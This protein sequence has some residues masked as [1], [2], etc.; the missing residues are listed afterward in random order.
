MSFSRDLKTQLCENKSSECC[1]KAECYGFMLF[2]QSFS[3][4][5]ISL[6]TDNEAVAKR[7]AYLISHCFDITAKTEVNKAK[8]TNYKVY[9]EKEAERKR[10]LNLLGLTPDNANT[11]IN[12]DI[13]KKDCCKNA[14]IRGM[15][16]GCGQAADPERE[17]RVD[18]RIKNAE[19]SYAAFDLLYKRGLEPRITLKN[20]TNVVYLKRSECV[21]DFLTLIGAAAL[22]LQVMDARVIKDFRSKLNRKGNFED[23]NTSKVINASIEQ[24]SA[25]EFLIETDKFS[26]LTEELQYAAK[27]RLDNPYAPLSELCKI[28]SI[29][30]TRSGLN[31]RLKKIMEIAQEQRKKE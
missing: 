25:I 29:P 17:Y 15:F 13:I 20:L 11:Y 2:G 22:S 4:Q 3:V 21:E 8:K 10:I 30:I 19:L 5:K 28:S 9:I 18:L 23:A 1:R 14:F 26:L 27:L 31:H 6:L 12:T 7:Y 16:L 24:R